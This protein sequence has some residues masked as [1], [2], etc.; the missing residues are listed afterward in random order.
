MLPLLDLYTRPL[1]TNFNACRSAAYG[2]QSCVKDFF[3]YT[4][5]HRAIIGSNPITANLEADG[6]TKNLEA[7]WK[8]NWKQCSASSNPPGPGS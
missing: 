7:T 2:S 8:H 6:N 1:L 5:Q 3:S 4:Y